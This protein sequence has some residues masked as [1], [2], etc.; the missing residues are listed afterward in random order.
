MVPENKDVYKN[1]QVYD[2]KTKSHLN[3]ALSSKIWDN[4]RTKWIIK[5]MGNTLGEKSWY[6]SFQKLNSKKKLWKALIYR[7][8]KLI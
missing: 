8:I 3:R 2:K 4:L 7:R 6:D 1:W 5:E